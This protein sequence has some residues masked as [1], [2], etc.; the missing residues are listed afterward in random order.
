MADC[1]YYKDEIC[2]NADC[3]MRADYCPVPDNPGVCRYEKRDAIENVSFMPDGIHEL[4]KH[5][6]EEEMIL[7]NVTVQILKCK[8]CGEVSIGWL[9][10][11]NTV[12]V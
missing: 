1:K 6:F 9:R 11:D 8:T 5:Q 12:Q 4:S 7:R 10:Q 3:P 2:V